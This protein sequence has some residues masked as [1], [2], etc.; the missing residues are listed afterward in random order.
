MN[1]T[2]Q[3]LQFKSYTNGVS[4]HIGREAN[5]EEEGYWYIGTTNTGVKAEGANARVLLLDNDF[6]IIAINPLGEVVGA[7]PTVTA[8]VCEGDDPVAGQEIEIDPPSNAWVFNEHWFYYGNTNEN[9]QIVSYT[10]KILK[11]PKGF[12]GGAFTFTNGIIT[13]KFNLSTITSEKDYNIVIERT[14]INSTT[15][16][17]TVYITVNEMD[18]TG[19]KTYDKDIQGK[20]ELKGVTSSSGESWAV[21]YT[22]GQTTPVE[23]TL[24]VKIEGHDDLI[25]WDKETIE[26]VADG[27]PGVSYW[28]MRDTPV[29]AK[30]ADGS[31]ITTSVTFTPMMQI[32]NQTPSICGNNVVL[33]IWADDKKNKPI[34]NIEPGQQTIVVAENTNGGQTEKIKIETALHCNMYLKNSLDDGILIDEET[35]EVLKDGV[36]ISG[37]EYAIL[38][39]AGGEPPANTEWSDKI[40]E[41]VEKG[42]YLWTKTTYS[43]GMVAYTS[44]YQSND[45]THGDDSEIVYAYYVTREQTINIPDKPNDQPSLDPIENDWWL[46]NHDLPVG[47]EYP[48]LYI[49]EGTKKT[50]YTDGEVTTTY[51]WSTPKLHKAWHE[52]EIDPKSYAAFLTATNFGKQD[53]LYWTKGKDTGSLY[54]NASYIKTGLFEVTKDGE[55]A[56]ADGSNVLLYAGWNKDTGEGKVQLAGWDVNTDSISK[57]DVYISSGDKYLYK[58]NLTDKNTPA[59]FAAGA[60]VDKTE[61]YM[62]TSDASVGNNNAYWFYI[63]FDPGIQINSLKELTDNCQIIDFEAQDDNEIFKVNPSFTTQGTSSYVIWGATTNPKMS[64]IVTVKIRGTAKR[65]TFYVLQDGSLRTPYASA[66]YIF[67]R[68][69]KV[70]TKWRFEEKDIWSER[71]IGGDTYRT[72]LRCSSDSTVFTIRKTNGSTGKVDWPFSISRGGGLYA[73]YAAITELTVTGNLNVDGNIKAKGTITQNDSSDARIKNSIETLPLQ[74]DTFFDNMKPCRYKYNAGESNRY[75]TGYIAQELVQALEGAGLT[76]QDFAGVMLEETGTENECWYLR[77]DEFVALNTW[78]IQKLKPRMTAVETEIAQLKQEISS[79]KQEIENLKKV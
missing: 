45:G 8:I 31:Y 74:Y 67:A 39:Q 13:K 25:T 69:L 15:N 57:E 44:S 51:T 49:C 77:R 53:T 9:N 12:T 38:D 70:G 78:Q 28:I 30:A 16:G 68:S 72:I 1:Y 79:L 54:I 55:V 71:T 76:T 43:N 48:Y 24:K 3:K 33:R 60:T 29:I 36:T 58:S 75:H 7:L 4:P 23:L 14:L 62:G 46:T 19:T 21:Q 41:N 34:I 26:F 22:K 18:S 50:T 65:P 32:G 64:V 52:S 27:A 20:L 6:D 17:G 40:P 42:K 2:S 10:L 61:T 37:V 5:G 11:L 73:A 35:V 59:R 63:P 66:E 56:N 47:E